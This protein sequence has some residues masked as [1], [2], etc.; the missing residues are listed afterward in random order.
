MLHPYRSVTPFAVK[1]VY[2]HLRSVSFC[3]FLAN[4]AFDCDQTHNWV[5][6]DLHDKHA[7]FMSEWAPCLWACQSFNDE[8][9]GYMQCRATNYMRAQQNLF[10]HIML[11]HIMINY[12]ITHI[13]SNY[14]VNRF[15][16]YI[17][18]TLDLFISAIYKSLFYELNLQ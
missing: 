5:L 18:E 16:F 12:L 3:M 14:C 8:R 9:A 2:F 15:R 11:C 6:T 7:V 1:A 10:P 17:D 4:A 13:I